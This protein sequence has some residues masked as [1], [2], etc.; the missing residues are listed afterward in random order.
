MGIAA[1]GVSG[2]SDDPCP[3]GDPLDRSD[4]A[5]GTAFGHIECLVNN[6]GLS[7]KSRGDLFDVSAES[8]APTF[9]VN[10]RGAFFSPRRSVRRCSRPRATF[11]KARDR[12]C[13]YPPSNAVIAAQERSGVC[14]VQSDGRQTAKLLAILLAP[15]GITVYEVSPPSH[16]HADERSGSVTF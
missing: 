8:Y 3:V 15:N 14:D 6:A 11:P 12:S 5:A 13:S 16:S 2:P 7:A 1:V 10:A 9:A 4:F